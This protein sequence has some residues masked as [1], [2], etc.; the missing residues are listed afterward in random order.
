MDMKTSQ[1]AQLHK[2]CSC[3]ILSWQTSNCHHHHYMVTSSTGTIFRLT[4]PLC[5]KITGH[6]WIPLKKAS[7]AGALMC[8]LICAW[9]TIEMPVIWDAIALIMASVM[10]GIR[11]LVGLWW[12]GS[13]FEPQKTSHARPHRQYVGCRFKSFW[14]KLTAFYMNIQRVD[15]DNTLPFQS[16]EDEWKINKILTPW[17]MSICSFGDYIYIYIYV[18]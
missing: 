10:A 15:N 12:A 9:T 8:S 4:G 14:W 7:G 3:G 11:S 5:V 18:Q 17:T 6:R 2:L 13:S 16:S 1:K